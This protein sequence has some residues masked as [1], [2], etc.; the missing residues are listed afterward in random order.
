MASFSLK[1]RL[2][3]LRVRLNLTPFLKVQLDKK[4]CSKKSYRDFKKKKK[5]MRREMAKIFTSLWLDTGCQV[6]SSFIYFFP[7]PLHTLV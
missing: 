4:W 5:L 1:S 6:F 3:L 7:L 2:I